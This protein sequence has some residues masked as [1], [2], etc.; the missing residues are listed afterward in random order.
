[1]R[2]VSVEVGVVA[3]DAGQSAINAAQRGREVATAGVRKS[4]LG[5]IPDASVRI[6]RARSSEA[7]TPPAR[8]S[9]P[10]PTRRSPL[11]PSC[12]RRA[13]RRSGSGPYRSPIFE[14]FRQVVVVAEWRREPGP[15]PAGLL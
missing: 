4:L 10:F 11:R 9:S 6:E 12:S 2:D 8:C 7:L 3:M 1:M 5:E 13:A 15:P 14:A